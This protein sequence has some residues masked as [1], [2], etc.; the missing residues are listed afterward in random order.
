MSFWHPWIV[1]LEQLGMKL[2]SEEYI[3]TNGTEHVCLGRI[4]LDVFPD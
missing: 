1:K 2:Q 3:M 4:D